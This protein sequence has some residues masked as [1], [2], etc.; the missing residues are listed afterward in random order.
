MNN[1]QIVFTS[2]WK[3]EIRQKR[4]ETPALGPDE[5][6]VRKICT[7]VSPGTE[8]ACL[9]GNESWFRMPGIP[10][11]ASV[12]EV[13][14]TGD[15]VEG[16]AAGD[17]V[18][19]YGD[20]S[21]YS[22]VSTRHVWLK[23]PPSLPLPWVPFARMAAVAMTS[24]RVSQIELGDTVAVTGLGLVGNM[25]SQLARLQG[26]TVIGID[27]SEQRLQLAK[28]CGADHVLLG[29]KG[30]LRDEVMRIT[31]G[32]GV[33]A[34]IEATGVPKVAVD[35]LPLVGR[36]GEVILL[37][38]PRGDFQT[39]V[40]EL[41]NRIHLDGSY[42]NLTFKGAHEWR[43]PVLPD[44]FAKHSLARNCGIILE[45][46]ADGRLRIEPLISHV[47]KPEEAEQA[48]QGLRNDKDRYNGVLFD[49]R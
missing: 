26:A 8:L 29:G 22:V 30:E 6:W 40:T 37:G 15:N 32:Q 36:F 12:S 19:H 1:K 18:F 7:L 35:H 25:A 28:A 39:N 33:S 20:H 46:M 2:P 44:R 13:L 10:G 45:L 21:A 3:A 9:S 4:L 47:L 38:S 34:L 17:I 23:V 14:Q 49:W 27:L 31:N 43:Y 5:A 11:Y 41:L 24:L 16:F 42:G 48:Y